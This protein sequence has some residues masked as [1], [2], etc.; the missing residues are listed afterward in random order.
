MMPINGGWPRPPDAPDGVEALFRRSPRSA[1]RFMRPILAW[2]SVLALC[3]AAV[4]VQATATCDDTSAPCT[5]ARVWL[6]L[7][8]VLYLLHV[9]VRV[10]L[11][12]RIGSRLPDFVDLC[13]QPL[14]RLNK[15]LG[16]ANF[17]MIVAGVG[18]SHWAS[19]ALSP[20]LL[21]HAAFFVARCGA[22]LA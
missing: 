18:I 20:L 7:H 1:Q 21:V 19:C 13:R 3:V 4:N 11:F 16:S 14:W 5:V 17:G 2:T 6:A 12:F 15:L 9:P 8:A 10:V 22:T